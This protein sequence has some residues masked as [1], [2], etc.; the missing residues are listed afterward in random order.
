[1]MS[2]KG[3]DKGL[4]MIVLAVEPGKTANATMLTLADGRTRTLS[5][6]KKKKAMHV[7]PTNKIVDLADVGS[8]GLQDADIRKMLGEEVLPLG[9]G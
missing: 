2:K 4:A 3:R 9:E 5:K 8:R 1:M 7:Q 6:P